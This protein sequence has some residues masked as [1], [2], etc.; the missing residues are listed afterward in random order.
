MNRSIDYIKKRIADGNCNGMTTEEFSNMAWVSSEFI[1]KSDTGIDI[2]ATTKDDDVV[3]DLRYNPDA[4][5]NYFTTETCTCDGTLLFM[6]EL[7]D[8]IAHKIKSLNAYYAPMLKDIPED[9]LDEY[10]M[11]YEIGDFVTNSYIIEPPDKSKPW[12][13]DKFTVMLPIRFTIEKIR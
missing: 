1:I 9:K 8:K 13:C 10:K 3:A 11:S 6:R 4:E 5:F 7:M 2:I 12:L